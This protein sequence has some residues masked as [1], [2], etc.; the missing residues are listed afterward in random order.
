MKQCYNSN[1]TICVITSTFGCRMYRTNRCFRLRLRHRCPFEWR[2]SV[3][4]P[5]RRIPD[6]HFIMFSIWANWDFSH[7]KLC[8]RLAEC[9]LSFVFIKSRQIRKNT[10]MR[11]NI[12]HNF[13]LIQYRFSKYFLRP[14]KK[15]VMLGFKTYDACVN[16]CGCAQ[17]PLSQFIT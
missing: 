5:K 7:V 16:W 14:N 11:I 17:V 6:D 9:R 12:S 10:C 1:T 4:C 2:N 8:I 15:R 13:S 3:N